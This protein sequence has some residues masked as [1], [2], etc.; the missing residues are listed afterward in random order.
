MDPRDIEDA[1]DELE[2]LIEAGVAAGA[3]EAL[4]RANEQRNLLVLE[5]VL[6]AEQTALH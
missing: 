6:E 5:S 2:T 3:I 1:L 4:A